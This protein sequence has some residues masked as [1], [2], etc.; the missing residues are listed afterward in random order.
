MKKAAISLLVFLILSV[1][2][3]SWAKTSQTAMN[4]QT[5]RSINFTLE[6][7]LIEESSFYDFDRVYIRNSCAK[8][9]W[10]AVHYFSL[11]S[12]WVTKSWFRLGPGEKSYMAQTKNRTFY[13]HALS[14][15]GTSVW[16]GDDSRFIV[17][18]HDQAVGFKGYRITSDSW[19]HWTHVLTCRGR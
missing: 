1:L 7:S 8:T 5:P 11:K 19:G 9:I 6:P 10:V 12:N 14:A 15:D 3:Q 16:S 13:V 4:L 18:G 2:N 17:K